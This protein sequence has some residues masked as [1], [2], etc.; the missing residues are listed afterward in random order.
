MF[1]STKEVAA[2]LKGYRGR[3]H[4]YNSVAVTRYRQR[5][6]FL[7]RNASNEAFVREFEGKHIS[8]IAIALLT[9]GSTGRKPYIITDI[10]DQA[11][12]VVR[13]ALKDGSMPPILYPQSPL[14]NSPNDD[15]ALFVYSGPSTEYMARRDDHFIP[16]NIDQLP[17]LQDD[18]YETHIVWFMPPNT[19]DETGITITRCLRT[20]HERLFEAAQR[21][22]DADFQGMGDAIGLALTARH[23]SFRSVVFRCAAD[24]RQ[25]L[26]NHHS[27]P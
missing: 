1:Y 9:D 20:Y 15:F 5:L 21:G 2:T 27:D 25:C 10:R 19:S 24:F 6:V 22:N 8:D 26:L 18:A 23:P 11:R 16:L 14:G 4:F 17:T 3:D 7:R 12:A 13:T